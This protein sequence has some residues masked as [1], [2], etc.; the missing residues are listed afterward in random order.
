MDPINT[1]LKNKKPFYNRSSSNSSKKEP[2]FITRD[3]NILKNSE[4]NAY[5]NYHTV[6]KT[7]K[8]ADS[9]FTSNQFQ[10]QI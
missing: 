4:G 5:E 1:S 6:I 7:T 8:R 9:S 3:T 2:G 10:V